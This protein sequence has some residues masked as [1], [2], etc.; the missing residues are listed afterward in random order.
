MVMDQE[1]KQ[2]KSAFPFKPLNTASDT[3]QLPVS[4]SSEKKGERRVSTA[5]L[6]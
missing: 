6:C 1:E 2:H 5:I 3:L 4:D